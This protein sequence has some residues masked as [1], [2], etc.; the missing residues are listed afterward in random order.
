MVKF[1]KFIQEWSVRTSA[2]L[3]LCL[4][5]RRIKL[6]NFCGSE[7]CT[8]V[9][10]T[11]HLIYGFSDLSCEYFNMY[12]RIICNFIGRLYLLHGK[13]NNMYFVRMVL[14]CVFGYFKK[15]CKQLGLQKF[16]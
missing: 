2:L 16:E 13:A 15:L 6:L 10:E 1:T 12:V 7:Y 9:C 14:S 3:H 8:A 5:W 11:I 4:N